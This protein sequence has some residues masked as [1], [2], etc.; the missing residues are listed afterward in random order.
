[1]LYDQ[2]RDLQDGGS[3]LAPPTL[4][5]TFMAGLVTMA[6]VRKNDFRKQKGSWLSKL[7]APEGGRLPNAKEEWPCSAETHVRRRPPSAQSSRWPSA[8]VWARCVVL[9]AAAS[10]SARGT[11]QSPDLIRYQP[12]YASNPVQGGW[13]VD[14]RQ[15]RS[16]YQALDEGESAART[17]NGVPAAS[18]ASPITPSTP[19]CASG[20][21]WTTSRWWR[22][23]G[24]QQQKTDGSRLCCRPSGRDSIDVDRARDRIPRLASRGRLVSW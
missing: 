7:I 12:L 17:T 15:I 9:V 10:L 13:P 4:V 23:W 24:R 16:F 3:G 1:M 20:P 14:L 6:V 2:P 22:R 18:W 21:A 19:N 8:R 5:V 11:Q